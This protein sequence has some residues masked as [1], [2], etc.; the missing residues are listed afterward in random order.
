MH[1]YTQM[2]NKSGFEVCVELRQ[3]YADSLPVIMISANQ[4]ED[5]FLKGS[6]AGANDFV[7]KPILRSEVCVCMYVCVYVCV[8]IDYPYV[9]M[10][11]WV[12]VCLCIDYHYVCMYVCV[13]V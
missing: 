3:R 8:H 2:P 5:T 13:C 6:N 1:T 10:Y 12:Y 4:D 7:K 11:V 9:C